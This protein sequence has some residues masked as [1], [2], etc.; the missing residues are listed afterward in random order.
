MRRFTLAER[1]RKF[2]LISIHMADQIQVRRRQPRNLRDRT[3]L[4]NNLSDRGVKEKYRLTRQQITDVHAL[5]E[6]DIAPKTTRSH[7][8]PAMT[9]VKIMCE[10]FQ[11]LVFPITHFRLYS[12]RKKYFYD[13]LP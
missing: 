7:A 2:I 1:L 8:I 11:A 3:D 4:L 13:S 12:R 10:V 6:K 5:I 9:K